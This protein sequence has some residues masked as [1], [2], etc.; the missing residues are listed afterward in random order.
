MCGSRGLRRSG[1]TRLGRARARAESRGRGGRARGERAAASAG[2]MWD[3]CGERALSEWM[4]GARDR[5]TRDS[6][7]GS[8]SS[9]NSNGSDSDG[10]GGDRLRALYPNVNEQET[11]LPRAWSTKDKYNYIGLS[12]NNLRVHYKGTFVSDVIRVIDRRKQRDQLIG[13]ERTKDGARGG[14]GGA[15]RSPKAAGGRGGRAGRCIRAPSAAM[16]ARHCAISHDENGEEPDHLPI[17]RCFRALP[18]R[19]SRTMY[20]T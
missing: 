5:D 3:R 17:A 1:V 13:G 7:D 6:R 8:D 10:S 9:N 19:T 18:I 20:D 16:S 4:A 2:D 14:E 12:Q 15:G 11:P